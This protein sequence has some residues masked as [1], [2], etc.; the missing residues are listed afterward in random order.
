MERYRPQPDDDYI[1]VSSKQKNRK[2]S[3]IPIHPN[4]RA[5]LERQERGGKKITLWAYAGRKIQELT[6]E[7]QC[8]LNPVD[9]NSLILLY[10]SRI[11]SPL[12]LPVPPPRQSKVSA[13]IL[14]TLI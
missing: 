14:S 10:S 9:C 13:N 1:H 11:L 3:T 7:N 8:S 12:R 5:I 2:A 4:A 6:A